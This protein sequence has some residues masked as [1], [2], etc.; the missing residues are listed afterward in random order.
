MCLGVGNECYFASSFLYPVSF[1][2]LS[3]ILYLESLYGQHDATFPLVPSIRFRVSERVS[4]IPFLLIYSVMGDSK[5]LTNL[6]IHLGL[7]K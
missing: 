7:M 3:Y 6:V 4:Q 2:Y 1:L 5:V